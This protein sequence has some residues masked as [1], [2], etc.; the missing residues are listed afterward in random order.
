[1]CM[2]QFG[3]V[4]VL[5]N[6]FNLDFDEVRWFNILKGDIFRNWVEVFGQI[7]YFIFYLRFDF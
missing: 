2:G 1:M 4:N 5:L 3:D 7:K 6:F